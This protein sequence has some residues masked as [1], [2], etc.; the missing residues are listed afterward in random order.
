M[1]MKEEN[2][3]INGNLVKSEMSVWRVTGMTG[4]RWALNDPSA[5]GQSSLWSPM[6]PPMPKALK[7]TLP[8]PGLKTFQVHVQGLDLP[9]AHGRRTGFPVAWP[10]NAAADPGEWLP[11]P[12]RWPGPPDLLILAAGRP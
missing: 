10:G 3:R 4:P 2:D 6:A 7:R 12:A 1:P 9:A 8:P 5:S 11:N